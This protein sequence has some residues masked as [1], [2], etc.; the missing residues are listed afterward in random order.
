MKDLSE[1]YKKK[2]HNQIIVDGA[3][4]LEHYCKINFKDVS[5]IVPYFYTSF[6]VDMD[7]SIYIVEPFKQSSI[8][9]IRSKENIHTK[10][11][12]IDSN[13]LDI[14]EV[15]PDKNIAIIIFYIRE[16]KC[17]IIKTGVYIN[18]YYERNSLNDAYYIELFKIMDKLEEFYGDNY[19]IDFYDCNTY[20][21]HI[22]YLEII[23]KNSI[24]NKH[25]IHN[26][27][28]N[29][30]L[31]TNGNGSFKMSTGLGGFREI[32]SSAEYNYGYYHSHLS[33]QQGGFCMGSSQLGNLIC[34]ELNTKITEDNLVQFFIL[35]DAYLEW[36]S[37]EGGP[38]RRMAD[39]QGINTYFKTM[40]YC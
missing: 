15:F 32:V 36:E 25:K 39:L 3:F 24:G 35:L 4:K 6:I 22:K 29:F 16:N 30:R 40:I 27:Y 21:V 19:S 38:Y 13:D 5:I 26:L 8:D 31:R 33:S 23:I 9:I 34:F 10:L 18:S 12:I 11:D 14:T 20:K 1:E 2:F 17:N 7:K 37:L 28:I